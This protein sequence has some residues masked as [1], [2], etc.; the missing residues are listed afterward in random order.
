MRKNHE[1]SH[2]TICHPLV[3]HWFILDI[4]PMKL[5]DI[6]PAEA[7]SRVRI[8]GTKGGKGMIQERGQVGSSS[9]WGAGL[10][11]MG[12]VGKTSCLLSLL[13]PPVITNF[14]GGIYIYI[15]TYK[16]FPLDH[17]FER[18]PPT[19]CTHAGT[20]A[21]H[22]RPAGT[23]LRF[24]HPTCAYSPSCPDTL[25]APHRRSPGVTS[26]ILH[27]LQGE[28]YTPYASRAFTVCPTS[29]EFTLF[30]EHF[31]VL[32]RRRVRLPL[33]LTDAH[34]RC[35]GPWVW[36]PPQC[37][38]HRWRPAHPRDAPWM[39]RRPHL[40]RSRRQSAH[41]HPL[42]P[43][44]ARLSGDRGLGDRLAPVAWRPGGSGHHP[45]QPRWT[46]R[47][48][49]P[50]GRHP[51]R[52]HRPRSGATQAHPDLPGI[53]HNSPRCRFAV[54]GIGGQWS[55]EAVTLIRQLAFAKT[56]STCRW[57]RQQGQLEPGPCP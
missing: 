32:L 12:N 17:H 35:G 24:Y 47:H 18:T 49:P 40:P 30:S 5:P 3:Y 14:F 6:C 41:Q 13:H 28:P 34:C 20:A 16:P 25:P 27:P 36:W 54:F 29:P 37:M 56:R 7:L 31:R 8:A 38:P 9:S 11:F 23:T 22:P 15:Y 45:R 53:P 1:K 2:S 48:A 43:P 19:T 10:I 57:V 33:P 46:R 26:H 51:P 4:C 21:P 50:A 42:Q 55:T 44:P 39:R 52:R